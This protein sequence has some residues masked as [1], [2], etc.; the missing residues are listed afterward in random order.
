MN[1]AQFIGDMMTLMF[2]MLATVYVVGTLDNWLW[3]LKEWKAN[4]QYRLHREK[5]SNGQIMSEKA[6]EKT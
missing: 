6:R 1:T 3:E 5:L 2:S 4:R